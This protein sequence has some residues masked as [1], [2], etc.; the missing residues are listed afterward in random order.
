MFPYMYMADTCYDT[1]MHTH[2]HTH[3]PCVALRARAAVH[4]ASNMNCT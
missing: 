2:T 4:T 1:Y 3:I